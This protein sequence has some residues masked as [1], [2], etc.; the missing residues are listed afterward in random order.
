MVKLMTV[1]TLL[2]ITLTSNAQIQK[3][4]DSLKNKEEWARLKAA[5]E[6]YFLNDTTHPDTIGF[7]TWDSLPPMNFSIEYHPN[8][9]LNFTSCYIIIRDSL[10]ITAYQK[11]IKSRFVIRDTIRTIHALIMS[12]AYQNPIILNLKSKNVSTR[13]TKSHLARKR[14]RR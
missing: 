7:F 11:T 6:S 13:K 12:L 5:H 14:I 9:D 2:L 1:I 10:G 3:L 4:N 8:P